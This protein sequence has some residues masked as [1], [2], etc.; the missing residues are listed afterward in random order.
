[1]WVISNGSCFTKD[2]YKRKSSS[3]EFNFTDVLPRMR[4]ADKKKSSI[5]ST[6]KK[7]E[8]E[9]KKLLET[10]LK[11]LHQLANVDGY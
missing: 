7:N 6:L 9:R 2:A 8:R 3:D 11:Q 4:D 1:M 10:I 5:L